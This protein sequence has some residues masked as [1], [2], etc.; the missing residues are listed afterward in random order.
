VFIDL[1]KNELRFVATDGFRLSKIISSEFSHT[2][3]KDENFILPIKTVD[4]IPK[5]VTDSSL[6]ME[7]DNMMIKFTIDNFNVY[8]KLID[9]TFPN[10]ESV[11]PKDND[12][13]LLVNRY[14]LLSAL[15]R[16]SIFTDKVTMKVKF[17]VVGGELTIK[18]DNPEIG[19]EGEE[20]I[21][22]D[23]KTNSGDEISDAFS[24]AF[25]VSYL[26]EC[27]SQ[28]ETDEVI[29]TFSAP[30]KASILLP[31]ASMNEEDFMELIMPVRVG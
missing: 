6:V 14:D 17:E 29:F 10:Y 18:S 25:N 22:C 5:I 28:I 26:V 9:D 15:R 3:S 23:F 19:G 11:I 2:N 31:V 21:N 4:L 7:F 13:K 8:S 16:A 1:R 24:I 30:A 20:T 27:L 12:K